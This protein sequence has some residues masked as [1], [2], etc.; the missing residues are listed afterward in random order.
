MVNQ[1]SLT[2]ALVYLHPNRAFSD[3]MTTKILVLASNPA[4]TGHL[5]LN[6]EIRAIRE[7]H[8][9]SAK[10]D[11]FTIVVEP[12]IRISELQRIILEEKPR[13]VH[14]CGH[15]TGHRGLILENDAGKV[16]LVSTA[17]LTDLFTIFNRRIECVVLNA[18]HTLSQGEQIQ[19]QINF[20][21]ATQKEIR[22]DAALLFTKGFY[23]ALFRGEN[24]QAAYK[25]GCNRIHLELYGGDTSERKLVPVYDEPKQD[26]LDLEQHEILLFLVKTPPNLIFQDDIVVSNY[27]YPQNVDR[28]TEGKNILP[29]PYRGLFNFSPNDAEFFFGRDVF[30]ER[31]YKAT[32]SNNL[33]PVL[34]TSGS[35]KSSVVLAGLVPK[36]EQDGNWKFAHFRPGDEPFLALAKALLPYYM[37]E[38]D[39]IDKTEQ[40]RKLATKLA[41]GSFPLK[42]IFAEIET[43]YPHDRVLLIADQFEEIF[44]LGSD[45][46]VR[47][48]WLDLLL[49]CFSS[50]PQNLTSPPILIITMRADFLGK[51]LAYR[52]LADVLNADIKLGA[53]NREELSAVILK[54]AALLGVEFE[55]GLA[56]RILDDVDREPGNL[57]LLEFA[58]TKLWQGQKD[59][60]LSHA[61]YESIGKVEG[62]LAKYAEEKYQALKPAEQEQARQIFIQLVNPGEDNNNTRRRVNRQQ[63]GDTNWDLV[64]RKGGLADSRLVVT[65]MSNDE[66]ETLEVVHEAL[67]RHWQRLQGWL[68]QDR[69]NLKKQRQIENAA[70]EWDKSGK[71]LDYL[72]ANKR[73]R[74]LCNRR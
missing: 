67:I 59:N 14:F 22:D 52:P 42:D 21:I 50:I 27:P 46:Q 51:A 66:R 1:V 34:G 17:A 64:T 23:D 18:C 72:L 37:P 38:L 55:S 49:A 53:M 12:A 35:G 62:A 45:E 39:R 20:L 71:K 9:S 31:L 43:N 65:G 70:E 61:A 69:D 26:Y 47:Q 3:A 33:I 25:L 10:R 30:I 58:L 56:D 11:E 73:L 5:Q 36:L 2:Y 7:A 4:E 13:I 32:K 15:G 74:D 29:C 57:A 19:Q 54:P 48:S 63:I 24:Y 40:S 16:Q 8:K 60:Q 68:N 41:D 28:E 44:T 6:D